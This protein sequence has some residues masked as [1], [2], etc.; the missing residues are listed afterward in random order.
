MLV[1]GGSR[2]MVVGFSVGIA[3]VVDVDGGDSGWR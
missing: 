3:G 1:W 2:V